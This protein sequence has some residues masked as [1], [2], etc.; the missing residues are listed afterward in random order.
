MTLVLFQPLAFG[1]GVAVAVIVGSVV[2]TFKVTLVDALFPALS[3]A[4]PVMT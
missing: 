4:I 1:A 2:L 3:L